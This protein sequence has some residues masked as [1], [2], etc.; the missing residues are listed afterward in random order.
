MNLLQGRN[1]LYIAGAFALLAGVLGYLG[2][3]DRE[4]TL[5]A[6]WDTISVVVAS[7]DLPEGTVLSE[8]NLEASAMPER[9]FSGSMLRPEEIGTKHVLGRKVSVPMAKGDPL[10]WTFIESIGSGNARL[11]DAITKKTRALSIR[12]SPESSV[13]NWIRPFDRVDIMATFRDP[14]SGDNVTMT[15]L[16][17]VVILATGNLTGTASVAQS[18]RSYAT[19]TVQVLPEA[20]EILVLAQ[21]LGSLYLSLRNAEDT[22][23][24]DNK[25]TATSLKTIV[26]GERTRM[27]NKSSQKTTYQQIEVI[28]GARGSENTRF[29]QPK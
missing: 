23:I 12:V 19:V 27:L 16:E 2:L 7:K 8:D 14:V 15:V 22:D 1:S 17:N 28:R 4:K 9:F 6:G 25:T 29:P 21:E 3:R 24:Q 5:R 10:L 13:Q 26:G 11:S 20:A 18:E